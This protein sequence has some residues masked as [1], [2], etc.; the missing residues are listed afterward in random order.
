MRDNDKQTSITEH[1]TVNSLTLSDLL[2][3]HYRLR[4]LSLKEAGAAQTV[5][6]NDNGEG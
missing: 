4:M 1:N 5:E 3:L 2:D 6:D